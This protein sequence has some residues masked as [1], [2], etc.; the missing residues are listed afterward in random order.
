MIDMNKKKNVESKNFKRFYTPKIVVV[1]FSDSDITM[2]KNFSSNI[3][4]YVEFIQIGDKDNSIRNSNANRFQ[5]SFFSWIDY[6]KQDQRIMKPS[7]F[8]KNYK[9]IVEKIKKSDIAIFVYKS[10]N[11]DNLLYAEELISLFNKYDVF[12]FHFVI[13][14]FVNSIETKNMNEK[15]LKLLKKKRQVYV[16]I[17]EEVIVQ[18]Y[19]NASIGN[20]DYYRNLYINNLIDL[21]ISPFLSP[22]RN[23]DAFSKMK[24]L[25]YKSKENFESPVTTSIGYS[26]EKIDN[27]DLALIQALSSPMFAAAF[28]ASNTFVITIKMPFFLESH[29]RRI[30]QILKEVIGEWKKFYVLTY[31]GPYDFDKY[32]HVSIMAINPDQTRL[33]S[34]PNEIQ[35][36]IKRILN[37]IQKSK[38]IF[39]N[40]KTKEL[41]LDQSSIDMLEG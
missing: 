31:V 17:K 4:E 34:D 18:T 36:C 22:K 39:E 29:Y 11:M 40:E 35:I 37:N 8:F 7:F 32:C 2:F 1:Y 33:I 27:V 19:K 6:R 25:F 3:V 10:N 26:D 16:P 28:E 23:P 38:Q 21:F 41:I 14:N 9:E 12:A 5:K 20:R 30:N 24:A 13:K 15:V